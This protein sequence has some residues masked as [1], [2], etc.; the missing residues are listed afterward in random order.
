MNEQQIT[1]RLIAAHSAYVAKTGKQPYSSPHVDIGDG[2]IDAW[3]WGKN[4]ADR[5]SFNA[6]T[7]AA[8][9]DGLDDAIAAM[10]SAEDQARNEAAM[11]VANAIEK[12][13]AAG[14]DK[15]VLNPLA[16][17]AKRISENA[18]TFEAKP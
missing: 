14:Y 12:C 5:L 15:E 16:D 2:S 3:M 11:A 1:D 4:I 18:L 13:R 10:P 6:E 9:L 17:L 7:F 8:A